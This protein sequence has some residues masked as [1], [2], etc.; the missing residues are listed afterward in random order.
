ML[1]DVEMPRMGGI[2]TVRRIR[3]DRRFQQLPVIALTAHSDPDDL[4]RLR[5]AGMDDHLSKP[6][7]VADLHAKLE[8]WT[9]ARA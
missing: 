9:A 4:A 5:S 8:R 1:L 2:E 6:L 3:A 7:E